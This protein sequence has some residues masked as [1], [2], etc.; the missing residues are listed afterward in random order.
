MY[1]RNQTYK[2]QGSECALAG[3]TRKVNG[4]TCLEIQQQPDYRK[5]PCRGS[6]QDIQQRSDALRG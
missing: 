3:E 5:K 2:S 6:G 4:S 1:E